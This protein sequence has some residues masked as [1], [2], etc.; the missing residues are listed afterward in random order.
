MD[1]QSET[2]VICHIKV[3]HAVFL[4]SQ[5]SQQSLNLLPTHSFFGWLLD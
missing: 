4:V 5:I 3:C 2:S 1:G